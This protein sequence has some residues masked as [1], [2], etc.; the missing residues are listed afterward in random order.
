VTAQA[1]ARG[2]TSVARALTPRLTRY[3]PHVPTAKQHAGLLLPQREVLYGGSA[4]GGKSDWLLASA[5]QYADVPGYAA[6]L[7]RRTFPELAMEGGLLERS[8]DWLAGTDAT[9]SALHNTWTFPSGAVLAFGHLDRQLD[10][11]R[12]QSSEWQMVGFDEL[13]QFREQQY[14]YLFSRL[15]RLEG[16]R[17]PIRMRSASNPGGPGHEWVRQRFGIHHA[18][19]DPGLLC[20]RPAWV[21]EH[22]RAFLPAGLGDNPHLDIREYE[23]ALAELP[24]LER[25]QLRHGDWDA[26]QPGELFQRQWF[27]ILDRAPEGC[28]WV[29]YWDLAATEPS[30]S[31][32]DPDWTAGVKLGRTPRGD[33][34]VDD[35]RHVRR[36]PRA[37]EDLIRHVADEDGTRVQ[38]WIEQEPGS[39][40]KATVDH[41]NRQV[42]PQHAV[43]GHRSTGSK[44]ERARPVSAKAEAGLISLVRADWNRALL[45][46]LERFPH[47][48]H[49]DQVDALSGAF[50]RL[51]RP[52]AP[53]VR[54]DHPWK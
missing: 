37:V 16:S 40:G 15:R 10:H 42:L 48:D 24:P 30:Q 25:A 54:R 18:D 9:W 2:L 50:S 21:R 13:T 45:D 32:T 4:G 35:V 29:R 23:H 28:E 46:E 47:G 36:G 27:A 49:D 52:Q 33:L 5:L 34:V 38:V 1:P 6:L 22:D 8:Q 14:R 41:F 31:N 43:R 17:I 20:Q 53:T 19:Q 11:L 3:V 26:H 39:S 12:Y 51:Q 44:E 7:L